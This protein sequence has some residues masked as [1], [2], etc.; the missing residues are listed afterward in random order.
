MA[1]QHNKSMTQRY[2]YPP[3]CQCCEH[4]NYTTSYERKELREG[5]I[6]NMT[7]AFSLSLSLNAS[8]EVNLQLSF[9]CTQPSK[10]KS[11]KENMSY[12]HHFPK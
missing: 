6:T 7:H 10:V 8:H 11:G 2:T 12:V 9:L 5:K 1:H 4:T 3:K